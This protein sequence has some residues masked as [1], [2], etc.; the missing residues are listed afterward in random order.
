MIP[1]DYQLIREVT[2]ADFD[3]VISLMQRTPGIT[4][5]DADSR[6]S[7][8]RYLA[9]NPGLSFVA[10]FAGVIV[11]CVMCGHDG[12]RGYLQHLIVEPEFRNRG[13]GR[14]LWRR[15]L[16]ELEKLGIQKTHLDVL[17]GNELA[18]RYWGNAGW[19]RR[20]DI[21]RYSFNRSGNR[22]A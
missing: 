11:G 9:R 18:N 12:R 4:V 1:S 3:A 5:R 14:R 16:D 7:T 20:D 19:A 10:E 15:C 2:I 22:N 6:E 17:A 13:I 21:H 8:E